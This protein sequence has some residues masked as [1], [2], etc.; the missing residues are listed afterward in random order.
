MKHII[1]CLLIVLLAGCGVDEE[2]VVENETV[3]EVPDE[4]DISEMWNGTVT[5]A[6]DDLNITVE[7]MNE[8]KQYCG[9]G[10]VYVCEDYIMVVNKIPDVWSTFYMNGTKIDCLIDQPTEQCEYLMYNITCA[11]GDVCD[12]E[13]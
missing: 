9:E 5:D 4:L 7:F 1:I 8:A 6:P 2:I 3:E 12:D 11:G 10:P 13:G